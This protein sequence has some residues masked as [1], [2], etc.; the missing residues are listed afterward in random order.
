M[1]DEEKKP[2]V[3][4]KRGYKYYCENCKKYFLYEKS[5]SFP[6]D[7]MDCNTTL[8]RVFFDK[9]WE[10]IKAEM[11]ITLEMLKNTTKKVEIHPGNPTLFKIHFNNEDGTERGIISLKDS[12]TQTPKIFCTLFLREFL[13]YIQL[14]QTEWYDLVN[15]WLQ[16]D[17][18]QV[19]EKEEID[20]DILF[21]E[22]VL[23]DL[24]KFVVV[25]SF[26]DTLK[27]SSYAFVENGIAYI[28]SKSILHICKTRGFSVE[29]MG[30][31]A[32]LLNNETAGKTKVKRLGKYLERFWRFKAEELALKETEKV[33]LKYEENAK[34][35]TLTEKKDD[36]DGNKM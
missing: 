32:N 4:T 23:S 15:F 35:E 16:G 13:Q 2:V 20:P 34:Q 36:V 8:H 26:E 9:G 14:K 11:P 25:N 33:D 27:A 10:Q 17:L 5:F 3:S 22:M 28:P 30:K 21:K 24:R 19:E 7:C 18:K 31:L 1:S 12:D 6:P 29:T